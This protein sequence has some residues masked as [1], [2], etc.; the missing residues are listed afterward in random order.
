MMV[1]AAAAVKDWEWKKRKSY[2]GYCFLSFA[3]DLLRLSYCKMCLM[4]SI[5]Y[6]E[7]PNFLFVLISIHVEENLRW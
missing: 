4:I 1:V 7:L 6:A 3:V 2:H 5:F